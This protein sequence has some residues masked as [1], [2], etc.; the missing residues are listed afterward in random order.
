MLGS[1]CW[2]LRVGYMACFLQDSLPYVHPGM[3]KLI[4]RSALTNFARRCRVVCCTTAPH[5]CTVC[6][7]LIPDKTAFSAAESDVDKLVL[8]W[9][10]RC[11]TWLQVD[12]W[13]FYFPFSLNSL[14]QVT[15]SLA[16]ESSLI[17]L[18]S[19]RS[20]PALALGAIM[21]PC[22]KWQRERESS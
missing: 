17:R 6:V 22:A 20:C 16:A 12:S 4:T 7:R 5:H 2:T 13:L 21:K 14:L 10:S 1:I 15:G 11:I 19:Q 3:D 18:V 9:A 8:G